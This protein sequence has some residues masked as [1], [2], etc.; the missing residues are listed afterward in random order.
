MSTSLDADA[1]MRL[2]DHR[3]RPRGSKAGGPTCLSVFLKAPEPGAVK[4]RLARSIGT[5]LAA[6]LYRAFVRDTLAWTAALPS[7]SRRLEF[8]PSDA[9]SQ[10]AALLPARS[11]AFDLCPQTDGDLGRRLSSA[12]EQM[13]AAGHRRC[14]IIGTDCPLLGPETV[15]RAFERLRSRDLVLSPTLDG[16]YAL[17]GL[18]RF[19]PAVFRRIDWS[20]SR[21]LDQ[22][23]SRA[24]SAGLGVELLAPERDIDTASDLAPLHSALVAAWRAGRDP[25]P[26]RTLRVLEW[27]L[28]RWTSASGAGPRRAAGGDGRSA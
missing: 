13:F 2:D 10:C 22:T 21:V 1:I 8:A 17:V 14:V 9:G 23:I 15:E 16:G 28:A 25:F 7:V 5:R 11:G 18:R 3:R 6:E 12:T 26:T 4:T 19:E 27:E 20:T 24:R